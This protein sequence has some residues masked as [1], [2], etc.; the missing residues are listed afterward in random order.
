MFS[1]LV[2]DLKQVLRG[3]GSSRTF[4]GVAVL[5]LAIG[6]G[7]NAAIYS[8]I[9]VLLLA[10]LSVRSPEELSLVYWYHPGEFTVSSMNSS[11]HRDPA[12]GLQFR[13]NYSYLIYREM[14]TAATPGIG[15]SGFNFLRDRCSCRGCAR[16]A[17]RGRCSS[18]WRRPI[19]ACWR[20]RR[21]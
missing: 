16:A 10:P 6:I 4:T 5:S 19:G 7:A 18:A 9:R 8:V 3:L 20:S 1:G 12:T 14:R 11:G 15:V 21:S 13:T 17:L 2:T